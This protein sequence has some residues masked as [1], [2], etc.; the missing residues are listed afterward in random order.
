MTKRGSQFCQALLY[1]PSA[2]YAPQRVQ[3]FFFP[4]VS[5]VICESVEIALTKVN[6]ALHDLQVSLE[7]MSDCPKVISKVILWEKCD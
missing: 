2:V 5:T 4:Y 6:T 1:L 7:N 3:E